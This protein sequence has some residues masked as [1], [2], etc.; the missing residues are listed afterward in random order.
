MDN[1]I[2]AAE[3]ALAAEQAPATA[4]QAVLDDEPAGLVGVAA[5]DGLDKAGVDPVPAA[6]LLRGGGVRGRAD[7]EGPVP[8]SGI[9]GSGQAAS[10]AV[11]RR[12]EGPWSLERSSPGFAPG[13]AVFLAALI[14]EGSADQSAQANCRERT[15]HLLPLTAPAARL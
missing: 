2:A 1:D 13:A 8:V 5:R 12:Y 4:P 11:A 3:R 15:E 9:F 10:V 7:L 6:H 14:T